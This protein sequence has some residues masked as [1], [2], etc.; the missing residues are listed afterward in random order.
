LNSYDVLGGP[1]TLNSLYSASKFRSENPKV[2]SAVVAALREAMVLI[3]WDK[4]WAA[5][6]YIEEEKSRL[7]PQFVLAIIRNPEVEFTVAPH[8]FMK[9]ADFM[10]KTRMIQE[11]PSSWKDVFF[12]EIHEE[13]G[14]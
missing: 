8:G 2:F 1:A 12:P 10:F 11:R 7:D 13:A 6:L 5:R 4:V 14:S 9:F 3:N